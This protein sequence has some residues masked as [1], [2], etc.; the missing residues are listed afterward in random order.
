MSKF[1]KIPTTTFQNLQLNAG[2]L[3]DNFTPATGVVGNLIGATTGGLKFTDTPNFVDFGDDID[4]CPKNV[5][6]LKHLTY[7]DVHLTGTFVSVTTDVAKKLSAAADIDGSDATHVIPR[8]DIVAGDFETLWWIGDY[9]DVNEDG[10]AGSAG[11]IAIKLLNALNTTGF[12]IQTTDKG[13]GQFAFDFAGH[14]SMDAQNTVPYE[15]YIKAGTD[16]IV[17]QVTI[18]THYASVVKGQTVTLTAETIPVGETVTWTENSSTEIVSVAGG[19]VTGVEVGNAIVTASIT[20]NGV[21][22]SDTCTVV[23]TAS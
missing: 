13:K 15:L 5:K 19:V 20:K 17:P 8:N 16:V 1:T 22:Y 12:Q 10:T 14:Y 4:N 11:Y 18:N 23:V 21:T 7:R 9:S 6:E 3:V 2:I